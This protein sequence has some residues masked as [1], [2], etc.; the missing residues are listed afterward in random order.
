MKF[1]ILNEFLKFSVINYDSLLNEQKNDI[2]EPFDVFQGGAFRINFTF[3]S[4]IDIKNKYFV[5]KQSNP[6]STNHITFVSSSCDFFVL[7][8]RFLDVSSGCSFFS[9]SLFS[10]VSAISFSSC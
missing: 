7:R 1:E 5:F 8:V 2:N 3:N 6:S 10:T 4:T 9:T